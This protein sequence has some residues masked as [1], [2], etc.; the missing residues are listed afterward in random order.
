[1]TFRIEPRAVRTPFSTTWWI[2][3][4]LQSVTA[5]EDEAVSCPLSDKTAGVAYRRSRDHEQS[6]Q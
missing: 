4:Y 2:A 6:P 5:G 1:M 3:V